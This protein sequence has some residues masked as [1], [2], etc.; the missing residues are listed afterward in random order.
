ML[1]LIAQGRSNPEIAAVTS[2]SIN[3]IKTYVR[4][5]YGKIG[6]TR[7]SQAVRWALGR[8]FASRGRAHHAATAGRRPTPQRTPD[9]GY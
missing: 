6:V 5:A 8:G 4:S 9:G 7:R 3:T 1:A 2:L